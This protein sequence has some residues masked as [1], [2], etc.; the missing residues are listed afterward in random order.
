MTEQESKMDVSIIIPFYKK[1]EEL[2]YSLVYNAKYFSIVREV[3]LII[4]EPIEKENVNRFLYILNYNINF[5]I[6][7]NSENHDWRNPAIVINFGIKQSNSTKCII[8]SPESIFLNNGIQELINNTNDNTFCVGQIIFMTYK[9]FESYD[10]L[11]LLKLFYKNTTRTPHY[12]GP[13]Y[14][15]S[16][17]CTKENLININSYNETFNEKGWG[18]ED[19]DIRSRLIKNNIIM[20]ENNKICLVHL[21]SDIEFFNRFNNNY[22]SKKNHCNNRYDNFLKIDNLLDYNLNNQIF[23]NKTDII[24]KNISSIVDYEINNII[25]NNYPIILLTQAYNEE[26]NVVDFLN[27]VYNF[28]DGIIC[29]DD[30]STDNTWNL[31]K[32]QKLLLKVKKTRNT[33]N[34]LENRNLLLYL[35]DKIFIENNISV[36]WI[37]WLDFDER[38][39]TDN[40]FILG[41]RRELLSKKFRY[42]ILNIPF[43]HM[44]TDT[45]YN[46]DYPYSI[47]GIQY[48]TRIVRF[49][50]NKSMI[51]NTTKNLHFNLNHYEDKKFNYFFPIK[52][53]SYNTKEKRLK[54]YD[55]YVNN[56]DKQLLYQ[57]SY[58]HM[59][60]D[61]PKLIKYTKQQKM[62]I[63]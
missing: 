23:I 59:L 20:K 21:E 39:D 53:L 9:N 48:H 46:A 34:D 7:V 41:T 30:S 32:S 13:V 61:H 57:N 56:Y 62:F 42:N 51:I 10:K 52:H 37:L 8:M 4:D 40:N 36:G 49:L 45:E 24:I 29:L 33:F 28:V 44:W 22:I 60:N 17:C 43:F 3:I 2:K 5:I 54:K 27:N 31:L 16:I 14:F 63:I 12:I 1:F 19:N 47:N 26:N 50:K 35:L 15:G 38:I 25:M 58:N 55:M 11:H 18:G 6:Y